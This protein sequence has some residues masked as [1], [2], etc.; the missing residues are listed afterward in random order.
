M[1]NVSEEAK[2]IGC[3]CYSETAMGRTYMQG[4]G[5]PV[6]ARSVLARLG[7]GSAGAARGQSGSAYSTHWSP[8]ASLRG[9][10]GRVSGDGG[11]MRA[12]ARVG[13]RVVGQWWG[14]SGSAYRR[15]HEE[16]AIGGVAWRDL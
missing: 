15:D 10:R 1:Y 4:S 9:G 8:S 14:Q 16:V 7:R 6:G 2:T 12:R 13:K 11:Q 5:A 3:S